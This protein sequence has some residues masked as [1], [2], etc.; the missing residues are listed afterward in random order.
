[1]RFRRGSWGG[2]S[3]AKGGTSSNGKTPMNGWGEEVLLA[4][5][6]MGELILDHCQLKF[7]ENQDAGS[8]T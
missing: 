3:W 6:L 7:K 8:S 5:A 2:K 4:M 1:M